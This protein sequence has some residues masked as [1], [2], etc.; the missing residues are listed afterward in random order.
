MKEKAKSKSAF[1]DKEMLSRAIKDSFLKMSPKKQLEN[2]VMFLVYVSSILTTILF[3]LSLV[4][5]R[6]ARP[7]FILGIT[8]VLWFTVLF[9]NFAE[10]IA[11][12]RGKAQA[13]SLRAAIRKT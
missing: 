10:A 4:G 9:A 1:T 8:V 5:L 6:D 7:G 12:G 2:P 11:E 3:V 13:D